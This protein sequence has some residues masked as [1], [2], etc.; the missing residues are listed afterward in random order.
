MEL[1]TIGITCY[2]AE[3]TI[4]RALKSA[5][6]QDYKDTEI[7]LVD[8]CSSDD[9]LKI[10]NNFKI[11]NNLDFKLICHKFNKG[12][13]GTR[14][15][16][17]KN[18]K[19]KYI[20]FFD[21][22]DFSYPNRISE[23]YKILSQTIKNLKNDKIFCFASGKK[24][25]NKNY[26]FD[27]KAIGARKIFPPGDY[28]LE[29]LTFNKKYN[30][31]DYGS[32]TPACSLMALN[33][34]LKKIGYFDESLRRVEDADISIRLTQNGGCL[35]G[36]PS[37]LFEQYYS[38]G[39]DKSPKANYESEIKIINKNAKTLKQKSM[40]IYSKL[41]TK[42]RYNYFQ[43]KYLSLLYIFLIL[44]IIK[45][46]YSLRHLIRTSFRR[47]THDIKRY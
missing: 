4:E 30:H 16:I 5:T 17:I 22:D 15:S 40:Y 34:T 33:E 37:I 29:F 27:F 31:I 14:N 47:L 23:Q 32:G 9:S 10:I 26:S 20:V 8:D 25:Y 11:K 2:N 13:T 38:F 42:L 21:D 39:N 7:L 24:I 45:P 46:T 1:I 12:P 44:L 6:S 41:W 18:S 19:G 36:T 35:I 28:L 3:A 43:K